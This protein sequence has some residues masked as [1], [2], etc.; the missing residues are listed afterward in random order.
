LEIRRELASLLAEKK[1]RLDTNQ[2]AQYRP[3]AKQ[4]AFHA[5]G[6]VHRERLFMAGNQLGKTKAGGA[7]WAMHLTGRY[8]DWWE[9][10]SSMSR[11][12]CGHRASPGNRRGI[13]RSGF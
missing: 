7:E 13:I 12:A 10:R 6:S 11:C 9:A 2:L 4:A 8:P 1:R 3:Y 5:A